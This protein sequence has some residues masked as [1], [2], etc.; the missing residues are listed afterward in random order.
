MPSHADILLL[1]DFLFCETYA[2]SVLM[3]AWILRGVSAYFLEGSLLAADDCS[4]SPLSA[5]SLSSTPS[6]QR[7]KRALYAVYYTL[8]PSMRR[9]ELSFHR[10]ARCVRAHIVLHSASTEESTRLQHVGEASQPTRRRKNL[11]MTSL[12]AHTTVSAVHTHKRT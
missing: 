4:S 9:F 3:C 12:S 7:Y 2:R 5:P 11:V 10:D 1:S 6:L 8:Q